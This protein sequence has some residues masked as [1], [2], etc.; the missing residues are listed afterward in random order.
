MFFLFPDPHFKKKKHK[1]RIITRQLL[2]EYAFCMAIGGILYTATDVLDLHQWM[3]KHLS[4]HPL[5]QKL[6]DAEVVTFVFDKTK[7]ILLIGSN[8][9]LIRWFRLCCRARK[10]ARKSPGIKAINI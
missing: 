8:R 5:F 3:D 2:D 6:T 1:A 7:Y 4:E 10:K 9:N